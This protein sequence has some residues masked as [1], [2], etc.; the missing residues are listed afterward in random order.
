LWATLTAYVLSA[1]LLTRP[2]TVK[3]LLTACHYS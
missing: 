3:R 1:K 2:S